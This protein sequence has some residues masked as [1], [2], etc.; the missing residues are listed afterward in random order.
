MNVQEQTTSP[1]T[2]ALVVFGRD[3]AGKPHASSFAESEVA[4]A[5]KAAGLMGMSLLPVK[6]DAERALAAKVPKGR[7]FASGRAFTPFVKAT[8]FAELQAAAPQATMPPNDA[9]ERLSAASDQPNG[10]APEGTTVAAPIPGGGA[11][12]AKQHGGW[13]DIQVGSIVL[14]AAGPTHLSWH[15]CEVLAI[16]AG[17]V[18]TLRYADWP[19]EPHI[20]RRAEEVGLMHPAYQPEL[21]VEPEQQAAA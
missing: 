5:E 12:L 9:A 15:E 8:L 2:P 4:L 6:T 19:D 13:G 16:D 7:V 3:E 18:L 1:Q 11:P 14:A 20:A 21:P 17:G 10:P